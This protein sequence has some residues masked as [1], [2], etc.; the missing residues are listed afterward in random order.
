MAEAS[1]GDAIF[2]AEK[3]LLLPVECVLDHWT[4]SEP[5]SA[6]DA[7]IQDRLAA[8]L[9]ELDAL[10]GPRAAPL[11]DAVLASDPRA[12][13]ALSMVDALLQGALKPLM[14]S[15]QK[16]KLRRD[17][18][19]LRRQASLA[20]RL[21]SATGH[22]A[23]L[24]L[25]A[26][27]LANAH[28]GLGDLAGAV[29]PFRRSIAAAAAVGNRSLQSMGHGNLANTLRDSGELDAALTEYAQALELET[30]PR[31]RAVLL[32]NRAVALQRLG[33]TASAMASQSQAIEALEQAGAPPAERVVTI[34][35]LADA[36]L[37]A[38][39]PRRAAEWLD[40]AEDL[41]E[42]SDLAGRAALAD[43]RW[44]TMAARGDTEGA[45]AA[46]ARAWKLAVSRAEQRL[47]PLVG[48]YAQG[49]RA[50][51]ARR[52]PTSDARALLAPGVSAKDT[53]RWRQALA[54]LE[55]SERTARHL[56]DLALALR[57]AANIG[58]LLGDAGQ[59]K[60][61]MS[62]L[63]SVQSE[64]ARHG[65]ALPEAMAVGT[66]GA[67]AARAGELMLG[68]D[69]TSLYA[70]SEALLDLHHRLL[71]DSDLPN[72]DKAF[73]SALAETGTMF[74]E[75]AVRAVRHGAVGEAA[76][77]FEQAAGMARSIGPSFGLANRLAGALDARL[78]LGHRP[79]ASTLA[80][81]LQG[82]LGTLDSRATL[83]AER[84]LAMY[85]DATDPSAALSHWRHAAELAEQLRGAL[86]EGLDASQVNR[87]FS[88]VHAQLAERLRRQGQI[89]AAWH[90]LQHGKARR[91]LDARAPGVTPPTLA[92]VQQRL[93]PGEWLL[94]LTL[95]DAG[96]TAYRLTRDHLDAVHQ[97]FEPRCLLHAELVDVREREARLLE[98]CHSEPAL[99]ALAA[100]VCADVPAGTRLL[101][102][103]DGPLHNLPL[104]AVRVAGPPWCERHPIGYLPAAAWLGL[105]APTATDACLVAGNSASDLPGAEA[106]CQAVAAMLRTRALTGPRC[107]REAVE[108]ILRSGHFDIVHLALHGRGDAQRGGRASLL[109][110]DGLGGVEWVSFDDLATGGWRAN[111]VVFSG[112]STGVAGPLMGHE[113]ASAARAALE[114]GAA[115]VLGC[116]WP[117]DDAATAMLMTHFHEYVEARRRQGDVD[118]RD[119]LDAARRALCASPPARSGARWRRRDGRQYE[120][121]SAPPLED[122]AAD[123]APFVLLGSPKLPRRGAS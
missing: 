93:D 51:L 115:S 108:S 31:G 58:A 111:L 119:A 32:S 2:P 101:V 42:E 79:Q 24:A 12:L 3:L 40:R 95:E 39:E 99:A 109:F 98:L 118:L 104:H 70:Q 56:G 11:R 121:P 45:D 9:Q 23:D 97:S 17:W 63:G 71:R 81:E 60:A 38:D 36:L 35:R 67:I 122:R 117:V 84:M 22:E 21:A 72:D 16:A 88:R 78:R 48:H 18:Q 110:A 20:V 53:A 91:L 30:D 102:V 114:A 46:C 1:P 74:N 80:A 10:Y 75:R 4:S 5:E 85:H 105:P 86:P 49:F 94:D 41:V 33:E 6:L 25:A 100:A 52:L 7:R 8:L 59:L 87:G 113:L 65:L 28:V 77:L 106:E 50:S 61:A 64:A 103:P 19:M 57:L 29:T 14:Q 26:H 90:A 13:G 107:Q 27:L 73:E 62:R 43:L 120:L 76:R 112:C 68:M 15:I 55:A 54:N 47:R 37:E 44:R 123:W 83:V 92:D 69:V 116:L 66:L 82:L 89:P 96:I 34:C